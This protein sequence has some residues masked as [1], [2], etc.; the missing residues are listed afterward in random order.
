MELD[1]QVVPDND[2][3]SGVPSELPTATHDVIEVHDRP[4]KKLC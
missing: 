3:T 2:S 1:V 4:F